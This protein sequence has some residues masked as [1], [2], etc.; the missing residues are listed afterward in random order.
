MVKGSVSAAGIFLFGGC[1]VLQMESAGFAQRRIFGFR[2][3]LVIGRTFDA[4]ILTFFAQ[5]LRIGESSF[6]TK[7][8]AMPALSID[9][10]NRLRR[11]LPEPEL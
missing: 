5:V 9:F 8:A 6:P 2:G 10:E 7:Y 4:I 3:V 1:A 11:G